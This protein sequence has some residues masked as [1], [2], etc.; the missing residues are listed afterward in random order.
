MRKMMQP[1][2]YFDIYYLCQAASH[3]LVGDFGRL[4]NDFFESFSED[5]ERCNEFNK[6]SILHE[7][8][9]WVVRQ[10][11]WDGEEEEERIKHIKGL[12]KMREYS[13]DSEGSLWVDL[14]LNHYFAK[15]YD[16]LSW[17]ESDAQKTL[18]K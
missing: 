6:F 14:A 7:Y 4:I 17:L 10:N 9:Q 12:S 5:E 1:M 3:L 8:C 13:N 18:R 2:E 16:F 15:T 11:I